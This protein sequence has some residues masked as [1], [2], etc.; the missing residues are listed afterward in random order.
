MGEIKSANIEAGAVMI[1]H[2]T[3]KFRWK[4]VQYWDRS[5]K[6]TFSGNSFLEGYSQQRTDDEFVLQQLWVCDDFRSEE[7]VDVEIDFNT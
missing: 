7:W 6:T 5:H 2:P 4:R 1:V 3:M